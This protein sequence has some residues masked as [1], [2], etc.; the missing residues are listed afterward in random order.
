M[1]S[2]PKT[3]I[4]VVQHLAPGGLETLAINMLKFAKPDENV[5]L[6]S[7]EGSRCETL[8]NWPSLK[9]IEDKL[10]FLTKK[11]GF[12]FEAISKLRKLFKQFKPRVVHTHHIGPLIYG[13]TAAKLAGVQ[14]IVHTEHDAWHLNNQKHLLLQ[15][16]A[17]KLSRPNLVADAGLVKEQLDEKLNYANITVIKNGIDCERFKPGSQA[18][19]RCELGLPAHGK[20]IGSAG[21]LEKVKGHDILL[22]ALP[23]INSNVTLAIAGIGSQKDALT[24]L[25][26]DLSISHQVRFLDLVEDMPTF[27]RALD[28]FCMPSRCEGFPLAPLEAQACGVPTVAT[29][30]GGTN[31]TLCPITSQ[32]AE[33]ENSSELALKLSQMLLESPQS[34]P[35]QF[36]V[37]NND[38]R[39][40]VDAYSA[41]T[42]EE[43]A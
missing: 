2:Q 10:I 43:Y 40:M 32:L 31:E 12:D 42:Q 7:L 37:N 28:V 20:I 4:H 22:K 17:L 29:N 16:L 26:E 33:A 14:H 25:A 36:V 35:R 15:S 9:N 23:L 3:T 8:A 38:I 21:R 13:A 39:K 5:F 18:Q 34:S 41:I 19:A 27:Y 24:R 11:P 1:T 30:V 6:I